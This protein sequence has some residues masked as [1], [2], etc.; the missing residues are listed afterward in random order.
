[1]HYYSKLLAYGT[2]YIV[3]RYLLYVRIV[4][5]PLGGGTHYYS[6]LLAY[7]TYYIVLQY[8]LYVRI[9]MP[10]P[11]R[12]GGALLFQVIGLRYLIYRYTVPSMYS[13]SRALPPGGRA[14][15]FQV[16]G[17]RYHIYRYKVP[18]I[19]SNSHAL[20]PPPPGGSAIL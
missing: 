5:P 12:G 6:K 17:L 11:P 14:L 19:Y 3:L 1:M 4:M 9:V 16:I 10:S 13:N 8:L 15:L 20:P 2:Y 18:T 7:G